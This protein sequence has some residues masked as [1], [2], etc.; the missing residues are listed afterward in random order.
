MSGQTVL[1]VVEQVWCG[2]SKGGGH[3]SGGS[4]RDCRQRN[5]GGQP[6]LVTGG[7]KGGEAA[8]FLAEEAVGRMGLSKQVRKVEA[9]RG[10][11]GAG[12]Q[13]VGGIFNAVVAV[14][15]D[16]LL[17]GAPRPAAGLFRA[18]M[19]PGAQLRQ[20]LAVLPTPYCIQVGLALPKHGGRQ[21]EG[22][23]HVV[24]IVLQPAGAALR[25]RLLELRQ[26]AALRSFPQLAEVNRCWLLQVQLHADRC[27]T[28][29]QLG[30]PGLL[31]QG[32]G[33][34]CELHA[35]Q[36]R[37]LQQAAGTLLQRL[38]PEFGCPPQPALPQRALASLRKEG[39]IG[40]ALPDPQQVA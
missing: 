24:H 19:R 39:R 21:V 26:L 11:K 10:V 22:A 4:G 23:H 36:Q 37:L 18:P 33:A 8:R 12:E 15:A 29:R 20:R 34:I 40:G 13:H 1:H 6:A 17:S 2:K 7:S 27:E 28:G 35:G 30:S 25:Q 38:V 16:S 3:E 14:G 31:C 5:G 32:V 9:Q